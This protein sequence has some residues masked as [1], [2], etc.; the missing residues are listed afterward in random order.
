[1]GTIL[2]E[3]G[4][5]IGTI[6]YLTIQGN[7]KGR[8][9]GT[10]SPLRGETD[11]DYNTRDGRHWVLLYQTA[12]G[13]LGTISPERRDTHET[14]LPDRGDT[15]ELSYHRGETHWNYLTRK[16]RQIET[17]VP[18]RGN[19]L[20]LSYQRGETYWDYLNRR[21][22]TLGLS[23]QT[24]ETDLNFLPERGDTLGLSYHRGEAN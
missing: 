8:H 2:P 17:I 6:V 11:W 12:E 14:I 18:E 13:S 1:M 16:G 4:R 5:N 22:D 23:F 7:R 10:I 3:S 24:G 15:F 19:I 21:G 20:G 9:V